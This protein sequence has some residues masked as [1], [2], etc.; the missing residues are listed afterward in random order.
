M[1][2]DNVT[3]HFDADDSPEALRQTELALDALLAGLMA[4][5]GLDLADPQGRLEAVNAL[6]A[7]LKAEMR[8]QIN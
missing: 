4:D 3:L 8:A 6:E 7:W 2:L 5:L 1:S